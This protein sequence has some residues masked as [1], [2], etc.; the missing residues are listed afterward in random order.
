MQHKDDSIS[1]VIQHLKAG[2]PPNNSDLR[3]M[4]E[5]S[6]VLFAQRNSL[7][8]RDDVL[9]RRFYHPDGTTCLLYTSDAA[10]E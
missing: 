5:E 10:D 3:S 6:K 4:S 7:L 1:T 8:V 2:A 9:C